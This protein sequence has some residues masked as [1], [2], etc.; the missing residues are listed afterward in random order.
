MALL[1]IGLLVSVLMPEALAAQ[2]PAL[3]LFLLLSVAVKRAGFHVAPKVTHSLVGVIDLASLVSWGAGGG[4]LVAGLSGALHILGVWVRHRNQPAPDMLSQAAFSFGLK[5][6]MALLGATVYARLGGHIWLTTITLNDVLPTGV[7]CVLWFAM[8]HAA[9]G[10]GEW[11]ERGSDGLTAFYRTVMVPSLLVE[12]MPLPGGALLAY[13]F[14][15]LEPAVFLAIAS[16]VIVAS[17][18]VQRVADLSQAYIRR[19]RELQTLNDFAQ[20]LSRLRLDEAQV[21]ELV[22]RYA[23][24]VADTENFAISLED[25]RTHE[26]VMAVWFR[27]GVRQASR[28]Y[29]RWGGPTGRVVRDRRPFRSTD[30]TRE[31]QPVTGVLAMPRPPRSVLYVPL[32]TKDA[33][34]GVVSLQSPLA[35]QYNADQERIL[36]ALANQATQ[37]IVQARMYRAEQKRTRQLETIAEVS[38]RVAGIYDLDELLA[39]TTALIKI[40]FNYYHVEIYLLRDDRLVHRAGT[41]AGRGP[42]SGVKLD[43]TSIISAVAR[44][45]E[46]VLANDVKQEPRYLFDPAAP[47]T[48]AELV[49]PLSAEGKVLGVLEVQADEVNFFTPSDV[50]V[51]QTLADQV[52]LALQEAE[53]F[54]SVQHEA[55]ISNALLQVSDSM[56]SL[57]EVHD[58]LNTLVRITPFLIGVRHGFVLRW[59]RESGGWIG[60]ESHG[61]CT[62]CSEEL[63]GLRFSANSLASGDSLVGAGPRVLTLNDDFALRWGIDRLLVIPLVIRGTLLGAFCVDD[64]A[65][66]DERKT[67]LLV[68][69]A[70][71]TAIAVEAAQLEMERDR[72]VQLDQELTIGR[73]IQASLLPTH[74]PAVPGFDLAAIW[75]PARQVAGDFFDFV[76]LRDGKWGIVVADVSDKGVPAAIYMTLARTVVRSIAL[77]RASRRAP[78]QVLE[79]AN[80]II[81]ADTRSDLFVTVFYTV[82]DPAERVLECANAGH[83]PPLWYRA[84]TQTIEWF[85]PMGGLPLGVIDSITLNS[86]SYRLEPGDIVVFYTDGVT[87]ASS[88]AGDMFERERL[89]DVLT[90]N[91]MHSARAIMDAII[92]AVSDFVGGGEQAD[93]LTIVVLKCE[94]LVANGAPVGV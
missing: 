28:R 13:L 29:S 32:M 4:G 8:D 93:D 72:R 22:H 76:P 35:S 52:A 53:L 88:A 31:A 91:Q 45:A 75:L 65:G 71:Q 2:L 85:A 40:N 7:L 49:V 51:I 15:T 79:R 69:M 19:D 56:S 62:E 81:V 9:W 84:R 77:G 48:A 66:L 27:E 39:F 41:V 23:S 90:A 12:L 70:N 57:T 46:P 43:R 42:L 11:I 83:C 24:H 38:Q 64:Q 20:E 92:D 80:E 1:G 87:E 26:V 94:P 59:D 55:Y 67:S 16:G 37:E 58:I 36:L 61:L 3:T 68:G 18:A 82:L 25:E 17:V 44:T 30:I 33:V 6:T 86:M 54:A 10:L 89:R 21:L 5:V 74:P 50:F 34:I 60:G 63:V 47:R 14:A 78:A 73:A